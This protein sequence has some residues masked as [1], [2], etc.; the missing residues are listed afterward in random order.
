MNKGGP[1]CAALHRIG[2]AAADWSLSSD[3]LSQLELEGSAD[4]DMGVEVIP[5]SGN[6]FTSE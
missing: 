6:F 2:L 4:D 1:D 3:P 5:V